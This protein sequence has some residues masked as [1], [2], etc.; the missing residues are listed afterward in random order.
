MVE[1]SSRSVYAS[2]RAR[3]SDSP[4]RGHLFAVADEAPVF[5]D[6]RDKWLRWRKYRYNEITRLHSDDLVRFM[7]YL[8]VDLT[9]QMGLLRANLNRVR[10]LKDDHDPDGKARQAAEKRPEKE[11][12]GIT[13][14]RSQMERPPEIEP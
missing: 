3:Q 4:G 12:R 10:E 9:T 1:L 6:Q 13:K 2:E 11:L 5:P 7:C 14:Y 8:V